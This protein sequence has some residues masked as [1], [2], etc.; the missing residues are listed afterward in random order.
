MKTTRNIWVILGMVI[1]DV[2]LG[3]DFLSSLHL[4][5]SRAFE[6]LIF[7]L[8]FNYL[9]NVQTS[10]QVEKAIALTKNEMR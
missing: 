10:L 1:L 3:I 2:V 9:D 8:L 6:L 7:I 5:A 4:S